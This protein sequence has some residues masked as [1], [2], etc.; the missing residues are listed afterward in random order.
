MKLCLSVCLVGRQNQS[1]IFF[2]IKTSSPKL[3]C[4]PFTEMQ[5]FPFFFNSVLTLCFLNMHTL[6]SYQ[7]SLGSN[8]GYFLFIFP[9]LICCKQ[10]L[11]SRCKTTNVMSC[12]TGFVFISYVFLHYRLNEQHDMIMLTAIYVFALYCLQHNFFC[13]FKHS[14]Q[15]YHHLS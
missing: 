7:F 11:F 15:F 8:F 2:L 1:Q 14:C 9:C 6:K 4:A 10:F 5:W 13:S 12:I 3:H